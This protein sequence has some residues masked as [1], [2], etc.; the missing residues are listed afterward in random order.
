VF[1]TNR[2]TF[3]EV[4][5]GYPDVKAFREIFRKIAGMSPQEYRGRYNKEAMV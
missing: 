5:V 2:K 3:N 1:E 4:E